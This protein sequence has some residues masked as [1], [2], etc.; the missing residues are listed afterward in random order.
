MSI[1][2]KVSLDSRD[3][4]LGGVEFSLQ[5]LDQVRDIQPVT[6]GCDSTGYARPIWACVRQKDNGLL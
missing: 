2:G 3:K 6:T 5:P 1:R 4:G